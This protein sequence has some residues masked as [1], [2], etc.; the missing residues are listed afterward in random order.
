MKYDDSIIGNKTEE[1]LKTYIKTK[2]NYAEVPYKLLKDPSGWAVPFVTGHAYR[3]YFGKTGID[4]E[5]VKFT[6]SDRWETTDRTLHFTTNFTD[7]RAKIEIKYDGK[8]V[9]NDTIPKW[10]VQWKTG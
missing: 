7:V 8:V 10:E 2:S 5:N 1:E 4:F 3:F 6:M 9:E